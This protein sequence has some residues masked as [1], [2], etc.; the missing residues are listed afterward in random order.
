MT[1]VDE[2]TRL[3]AVPLFASLDG[4]RIRRLITR[5]ASRT[6][7]DGTVIAVR[8]RPAD[9]LIVVEEGAVTAVHESARGRRLRLGEF[10]APCAVDKA[11]V[12]GGGAY[13]ATWVAAGRTRLR[14]VPAADLI[15]L[16]DEVPEVRRHV[17]RHLA[18]QLRDRQEDLVRASFDDTASRV[19]AWL[20]RAAS[21]SGPRVILPGAQEG[22]AEA[23][24][25]TR[26]SV[27]RALRA[28][29]RD[30][31]VRVEPGAVVVLSSTRLA[32]R[33]DSAG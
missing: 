16:V 17:L 28:L 21:G 13:T 14:L 22:L 29:A 32:G 2:E 24:G 20:L 6:V 12:L 26:V 15:A 7:P 5:S 10:P 11:A 27:N 3:R 9:R 8:E 25:S 1:E 18:G 19:A 30:G 23:I 4:A 33:A 31:L